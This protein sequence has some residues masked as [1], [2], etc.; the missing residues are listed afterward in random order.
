MP[1]I[2]ALGAACT[3]AARRL[4]TGADDRVRTLRDHL[5]AALRSSVPGLE[6]NGHPE[7]RLPNTLNV[8]FPGRDGQRLLAAAPAIAA[9]T[10]PRVIPG[11]PSP[12]R[13]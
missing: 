11:A 10:A 7:R 2:A 3:L 12:R 4:A 8:S 6:L 1:Y 9:A 5:H 13:S